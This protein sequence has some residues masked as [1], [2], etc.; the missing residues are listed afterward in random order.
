MTVRPLPGSARGR[1]LALA[2]IVLVA[3][4]LRTAVGAVSPIADRIAAELP[5]EV[6]LL[7]VIGAAPPLLFAASGL[8]APLV[9]RRLGLE[10]ATL[11]TVVVASAGHLVRALAPE[12]VTLVVGTGLALL[13]AGVANVLLPPLVKRYFPTRLGSV[14]AAYITIMSIGASLAPAIA[15]PVADA[16]GW[17]VSLGTW[18]V[19]AAVALL[20]WVAIVAGRH[21]RP[22]PDDEAAREATGA[23]A[24][25]G[26]PNLLRSPIAWAMGLMFGST[27]L[28]AYATFAWLPALLVESAGVDAA[29]A[30]ALL[31]VFSI[32][33][34]PAGLL[35]PI[36]ANR[37][38]SVVPLVAAAIGFFA[39][40]YGGLLF[41]PAAAPVLWVAVLGLGP[42][43]FPLALVLINLRTRTPGGSV[44]LSGFVQGVGYLIGAAGPLLVGS[45]H[46]ATGSWSAPLVAL[47]ASLALAVPA[48]VVLRRPGFVED[49]RSAAGESRS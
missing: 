17:R 40:G 28:G 34:L 29:T 25:V 2:G 7:A 19:V 22:E 8:V 36:L 43:T 4:S 26:A 41:A 1:L 38:R 3:A 30:G 9:S 33:G 24:T 48:L 46:E 20:P 27:A 18:A 13:G 5:L 42:L 16:A 39:V 49:E 37:M 21:G 35:V 47:L 32:G 10:G 44:A 15:V 14:S 31:A 23:I 12:P 11:A 6:V 45:L